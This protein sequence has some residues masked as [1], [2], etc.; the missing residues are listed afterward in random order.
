MGMN[1]KDRFHFNHSVYTWNCISLIIQFIRGTIS[2]GSGKSRQEPSVCLGNKY[3]VMS[4]GSEV[5]E[6]RDPQR[7]GSAVS[8]VPVADL[9][10]RRG[11]ANGR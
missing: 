3:R 9:S 5:S 1:E 7:A 2:S 8:S 4:Y 10:P 6:P 11:R